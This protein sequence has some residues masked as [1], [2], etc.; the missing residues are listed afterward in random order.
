MHR[1]PGD[2]V[3]RR[4]QI[5]GAGD[6]GQHWRAVPFLPLPYSLPR[7]RAPRHHRGRVNKKSCYRLGRAPGLELLE[8]VVV[9]SGIPAARARCLVLPHLRP[10]PVP[11]SQSSRRIRRSERQ[12]WG[13]PAKHTTISR[14][15]AG[16]AGRLIR[17][18]RWL[19]EVNDV[20][21]FNAPNSPL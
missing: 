6:R 16:Q 14:H 8:A 17:A 1:R 21:L 19:R 20:M 13:C 7:R 10:F 15:L 5:Y 12:A 4:C 3:R 18:I 9:H 11:G 2:D